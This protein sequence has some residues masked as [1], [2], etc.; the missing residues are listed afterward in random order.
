LAPPAEGW[1]VHLIE[2]WLLV[3]VFLGK[4]PGDIV[5]AR[6]RVEFPSWETC[7][8]TWLDPPPGTLT[9]MRDCHKVR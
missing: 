4:Q 9:I 5:F 6:P 3:V 2:T 7:I 1:R 8:A